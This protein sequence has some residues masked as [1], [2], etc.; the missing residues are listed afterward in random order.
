[1]ADWVLGSDFLIERAMAALGDRGLRNVIV[2][3]GLSAPRH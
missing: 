1:M 2:Y 3:G